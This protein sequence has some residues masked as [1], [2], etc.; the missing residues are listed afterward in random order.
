[1]LKLNF[2]YHKQCLINQNHEHLYS[3]YGAL[4]AAF[5]QILFIFLFIF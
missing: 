5:F 4:N 2:M 3:L 1:M